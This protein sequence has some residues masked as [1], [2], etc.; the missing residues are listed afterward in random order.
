MPNKTGRTRREILLRCQRK[1]FLALLH[2]Q[3][4]LL[5]QSDSALPHI[6]NSL[7]VRFWPG[8]VT[9]LHS[10]RCYEDPA[11]SSAGKEIER[12]RLD[13]IGLM[14][15]LALFATG[16]DPKSITSEFMVEGIDSSL[17][18]T[19]SKVPESDSPSLDKEVMDAFLKTDKHVSHDAVT[20]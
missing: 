20:S 14:I 6:P 15:G 16:R 18:K 17:L 10:P 8:M 5:F 1:P 2:S 13:V 19:L 12:L 11:G 7:K 4:S 3:E 9:V